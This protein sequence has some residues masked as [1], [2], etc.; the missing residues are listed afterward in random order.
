MKQYNLTSIIGKVQRLSI[1]SDRL[2]NDFSKKTIKENADLHYRYL[3]LIRK[4]AVN[5]IIRFNAEEL[6]EIDMK[7]ES[8]KFLESVKTIC[9]DYIKTTVKS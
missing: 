3:I 2:T 7:K 1:L 9:E 8:E 6:P 4:A 5:E